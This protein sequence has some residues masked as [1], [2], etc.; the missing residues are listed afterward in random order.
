MQVRGL[1]E[2]L[3]FHLRVRDALVPWYPNSPIDIMYLVCDNRYMRATCDTCNHL[4]PTLTEAIHHADEAG[5]GGYELADTE[6]EVC[7]SCGGNGE[8]QSPYLDYLP[9][10]GPCRFCGGRG[11]F[12][13]G[14][15]YDTR[16]ARLVIPGDSSWRAELAS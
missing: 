6:L 2:V 3:S 15:Y 5:H 12:P 14:S 8:D 13:T 4:S 7:D 1:N 11:S 9:Q 16:L 10:G